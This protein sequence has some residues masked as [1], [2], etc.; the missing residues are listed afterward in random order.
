MRIIFT[1][2]RAI[3][4]ILFLIFTIFQFFIL[5]K[6]NLKINIL[7]DYN[8]TLLEM[9]DNICG[10]RH[11]FSNFI[12]ALDGYV[13][14]NNMEGVKTMSKSIL[15]EC[16]STKNLEILNPNVIKN[17]A[18]YSIIS[19]KYFLSQSKN[20]DMNIEIITDLE[21]IEKSSYQICRILAILL[22]NAIE[23]ASECEKGFINLRIF[24]DNKVKRK[25]IVIENTYKNKEID[26]EKVF[27]KGYSSKENSMQKHGL[28]L[29]NVKKILMKNENLNLYTTKGELFSQQLEIY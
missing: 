28:G 11:D 24:E 5:K 1:I 27:E 6:K 19:K 3:S 12:Q 20:I 15:K 7:E 9:N 18:I 23:S 25:V 13:Q 2:T 26:L 4:G 10:F 29:W 14:T 22:D 21:C 17:P 8:K 16:I